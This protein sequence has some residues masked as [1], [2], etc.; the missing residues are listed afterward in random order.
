MKANKDIEEKL[1]EDLFNEIPLENPSE[2]FSV[3]LMKQI[4]IETVKAKKQKQWISRLQIAAGIASI[5][6]LPQFAIYLCTLL[7]PGFSFHFT[8]I[9][10]DFNPIIVTIGCAILFLLIMD[11]LLR[12]HISSKKH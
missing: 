12:K 6:I 3:N 8:K 10:L 7:I 11:A 2:N 9:T 5:F 4:E 1:L